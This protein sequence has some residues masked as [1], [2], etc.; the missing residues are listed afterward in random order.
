MDG[1]RL[2]ARPTGMMVALAVAAV[3]PASAVGASDASPLDV[4]R[5]DVTRFPNVTVDVGL[6]AGAAVSDVAPGAFSVEGAT[7]TTTVELAPSDLAIAIVLDD[8]PAVGERVVATEQGAIAELVRDLPDGVA[9]GV[10]TT[11]GIV[12]E[13]T[14]DQA[15]V[16]A[17]LSR[18]GRTGSAPVRTIADAVGE[19]ARSLAAT[20]VARHQMVTMTD[21]NGELTA[22]E[23]EIVTSALDR[24]D[25]AMRA[26]VVGEEVPGRLATAASASGG[27]AAAVGTGG[28]VSALDALTDMFR[29]QYR[30]TATMARPGP[31][32]VV[33]TVAGRRY[34]TTLPDLGPGAP[35]STSTI[36]TTSTTSTTS[37]TAPPLIRPAST[38]SRASSTL[39][40]IPGSVVGVVAIV[41][42]VLAVVRRRQRR[43]PRRP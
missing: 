32:T 41:V 39:T 24:A 18:V 4:V 38:T 23:L 19:A 14:T 37:T 43:A 2:G 5:V 33:L 16:L 27:A 25:A 8:R 9:V 34:E 11:R 21:S 15:A 10:R 31:L 40:A 1:W 22:G 6:P 17:A 30:V 35:T 42:L 26:V 29:D 7:Q 28:S 12:V 13:P 3:A 20:P 36:A